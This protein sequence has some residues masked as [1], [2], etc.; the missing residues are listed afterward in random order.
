MFNVSSL[1]QNALE[2]Q[3]VSVSKK[4]GEEK[5][6]D[7]AKLKAYHEELKS[8]WVARGAAG[9]LVQPVVEA[10]VGSPVV[11]EKVESKEA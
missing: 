7:N 1:S 11:E 10:P 6:A 3:L 9:K 5:H 8:E 2:G 4:L